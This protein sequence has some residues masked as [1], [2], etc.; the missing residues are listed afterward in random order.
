M[1]PLNF[2][3]F[4]VG[5]AVVAD[6]GWANEADTKAITI[7]A[8]SPKTNGFFIDLTSFLSCHYVI[9]YSGSMPVVRFS[10]NKTEAKKDLLHRLSSLLLFSHFSLEK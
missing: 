6:F 8:T 7:K 3:I 9:L 2:A 10:V 5:A 4:S 1:T